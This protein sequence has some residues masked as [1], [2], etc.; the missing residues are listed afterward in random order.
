MQP[1]LR[2]KFD[3][4]GSTVGCH[5]R[6]SIVEGVKRIGNPAQPNQAT[7]RKTLAQ[8]EAISI[9]SLREDCEK[10]PILLRH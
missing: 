5:D 4:L 10:R 8:V 6:W 3:R 7:A 2:G 9:R 1:H